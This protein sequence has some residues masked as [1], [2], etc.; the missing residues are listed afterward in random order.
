MEAEEKR[1]MPRGVTRSEY[2]AAAALSLNVVTLAFGAGI[3]VNTIQQ[4]SRD[5]AELRKSQAHDQE[6]F[7][8]ISEKLTRIDTNVG[9][10]T[11][12]TR[13]DRTRMEE[14]LYGRKPS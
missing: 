8:Q 6:Q 14:R 10:L 9:H 4:H 5:I 1:E 3:Y 12:R 2:I 11:D 13:E 7:L